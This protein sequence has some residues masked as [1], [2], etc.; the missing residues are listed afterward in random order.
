MF[1]RFPE[2]LIR[3]SRVAG[4]AAFVALSIAAVDP[5]KDDPTTRPASADPASP[6]GSVTGTVTV[7][8]TGKKPLPEMVVFLESADPQRTFPVPN[9]VFHVSQQDAKFRPSLI[10]IAAGQS[11][12]FRNDERRQIEHNVFSRTATKQFDLG[13][14]RPGETGKSVT[15]DKPGAVRLFCSIHRYMDGVVLVCP[16]PFFAKVNKDGTFQIDGVPTGDYRLKTWQRN[17]RFAEREL[18]ISVTT[19]TPASV[20]IELSRK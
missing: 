20:S 2:L 4:L 5:S 11:V 7:T 19:D 16:T 15:F 9:E 10:V 13:L 8:S 18:P 14:Y 12:D 17:A 3:L 6:T 1:F